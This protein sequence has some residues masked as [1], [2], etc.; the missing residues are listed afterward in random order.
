MN[1]A[2]NVNHS[3]HGSKCLIKSIDTNHFKF[4]HRRNVIGDLNLTLK[5]QDHFSRVSWYRTDQNI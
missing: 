3:Q 5:K 1:T 4:K 2:I